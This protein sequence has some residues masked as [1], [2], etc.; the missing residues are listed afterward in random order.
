MGIQGVQEGTED[1]NL[2]DPVLSISV[3]EVM[4]PTFTTW[5]WHVRKSRTQLHREEFSPR[6]V[7]FVIHLE[8]AMV[9]KAEL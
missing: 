7:S 2:W 3:E 8:G 1:A 9:L 5:R 4:L 6:V